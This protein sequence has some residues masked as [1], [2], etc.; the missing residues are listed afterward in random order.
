MEKLLTID[1]LAEL[2]QVSKWTI[3][4][5]VHEEF[6]PCIKIGHSVRFSEKEISHWLV[7]RSEAGRITRRVK[8]YT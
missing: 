4:G 7:K 6:I 3:Y 5:W 8:V 2:L 1:Q